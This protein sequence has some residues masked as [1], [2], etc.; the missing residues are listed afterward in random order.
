MENKKFSCMLLA[1]LLS[2][3]SIY[4]VS[5]E[6]TAIIYPPAPFFVH[7]DGEWE[8][9]ETNDAGEITRVSYFRA[10]GSLRGYSVF[11]RASDRFFFTRTDYWYEDGVLAYYA[12]AELDSDGFV[13][14]AR[15]Y[16]PDGTLFYT[17]HYGSNEFVATAEHPNF[18]ES[19]EHLTSATTAEQSVNVFLD[20]RELTFDVPPTIIDNRTMVPMRVIF[21]ALGADVHWDG[22]TQTIT[23][24]TADLIIVTTI[25]NAFIYVNGMRIGMD[26]P[27]VIVDGRTLVPARFVS[28]A[29]GA[30]VEWN[31]GTRIVFITSAF[32]LYQ[33]SEMLFDGVDFHGEVISFEYIFGE[34]S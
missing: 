14:V 21:E 16:Y 2:L 12:V 31:A 9:I 17:K 13:T 25:G 11:Y 5:A 33:E 29:F 18:L 20:G 3:G 32:P 4:A 24:V 8:E 27:S 6:Q 30:V 19:T 10:D 7:G 22:T 23:A 1:L 15:F 26:V 34:P 28:E